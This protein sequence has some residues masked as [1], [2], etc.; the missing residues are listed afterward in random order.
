MIKI[1]K[2]PTADTRTCDWSKVTKEQLL[3]S[4]RQHIE[5]VGK[6][7]RYFRL[8]LTAAE[9][10]H[11]W[12]KIHQIDQ[13]HADFQTGFK[14]TQWWDN[15]RKEERHHLGQSDGV[16]EDVN[17]ID[18]LEYIADCIMAGKARS[19]TIYEIKIEDSV[20]RKAFQNTCKLL[21]SQV[22]VVD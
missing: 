10:E 17:L 1:K 8:L 7:L 20:L 9:I 4:S 21:E 11:D 12:T 2:S 19:G 6:A 22:N 18:V 3:A 5:D 15:H 16:R 14:V 13:F